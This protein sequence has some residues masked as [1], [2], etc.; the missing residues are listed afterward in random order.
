MD[1]PMMGIAMAALAG[2]AQAEMITSTRMCPECF[3]RDGSPA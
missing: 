2:A 3:P 1:K